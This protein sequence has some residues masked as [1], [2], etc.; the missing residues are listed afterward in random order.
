MHHMDS[1]KKNLSVIDSVVPRGS[2]IVYLDIPLH[3]NVGDLLIYKGTEQFFKEREYKVLARRTDR[4]SLKFVQNTKHLPSDVI[5]LLHGGGN[6]GD[7][8]PHH[9]ILRETVV[10]KFPNN[11]IVYM[12]QTVHFKS[13]EKMEHSASIIRQHKNLTIFCRDTRSHQILRENFC[14][15]VIMCPDMAHSLWGVFPTQKKNDIKRDTLW[16]IRKDIEETNVGTLSGIPAPSKYEDWE[17]ICTDKDRAYMNLLFKFERINNLL[18]SNIIPTVNMW[19]KHTDKLVDRVNNYFMAHEQ[20]VTSR[21]H[22]HI[23]CCLLSVKTKLL[24]NSYGKN[25]TYFDAWTKGVPN[26]ELV[27]I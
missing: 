11:K 27:K 9:Q 18:G 21:M 17:D 2:R 23:L 3:L 14:D 24:D 19:A 26:C 13:A 8:Y 25:S 20:V 12:P 5:I 6:F 10:Q 7:L 4:T 15:N 22:G 1:L 16:M